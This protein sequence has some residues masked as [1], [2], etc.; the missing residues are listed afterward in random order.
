MAEV[1]DVLTELVAMEKVALVF[2][3]ATVTLVGTVAAAVLL[4]LRPT[5]RPDKGADV[6][7]TVPCEGL[8]PTTLAGFSVS[9]LRAGAGG[10]LLAKTLISA[11][12]VYWLPLTS[13]TPTKRTYCALVV[14]NCTSIAGGAD[15]PGQAIVAVP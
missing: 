6:S 3:A 12:D 1:V 10:V 9:E 8:P 2:P 13:L 11:A 4:L 15:P 7:V 5:L 14:T